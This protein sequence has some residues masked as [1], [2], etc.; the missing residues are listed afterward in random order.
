MLG[1][2]A[3]LLL[4]LS[5]ATRTAGLSAGP[6]AAL[7]ERGQPGYKRQHLRLAARSALGR[8]ARVRPPGPRVYPIIGTLPSFLRLGGADGL[9][10]VHAAMYRAYGDC[11]SMAILGERESVI[12]DPEEFQKAASAPPCMRQAPPTP[13]LPHTVRVA[14]VFR[15]EGQFPYGSSQEA[16]FFLEYYEVGEL[17]PRH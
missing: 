2:R 4:L 14:Q 11:Y 17:Q 15:E 5:L 16:P 12:C 8:Q 6:A 9:F 1:G 13:R 7:V 3:R 10:D